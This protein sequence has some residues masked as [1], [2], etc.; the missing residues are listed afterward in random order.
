MEDKAQIRKKR[1]GSLFRS[2]SAMVAITLTVVLMLVLVL[3]LSSS[4]SRTLASNQQRTEM[5]EEQIR[6]EQER[7]QQIK[8]LQEYMQS[9]EYLE[10]AAKEKLGFVKDGEIIYKESE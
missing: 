6:A 4:L 2:R 5:L 7:T 3:A 1:R 9:D 8:E 10:K